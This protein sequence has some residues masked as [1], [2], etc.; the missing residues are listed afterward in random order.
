MKTYEE[1]K[2]MAEHFPKGTPCL[3]EIENVKD[4]KE[5]PFKRVSYIFLIYA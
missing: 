4:A 5:N 1:K 2:K 3:V